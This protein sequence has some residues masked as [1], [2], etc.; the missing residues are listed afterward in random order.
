MRIVFDRFFNSA[1]ESAFEIT[2]FSASRKSVRASCIS[3]ASFDGEILSLS[4]ML[5]IYLRDIF[6]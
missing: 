1:L 2:N 4:F 5:Q 3:V 6:T